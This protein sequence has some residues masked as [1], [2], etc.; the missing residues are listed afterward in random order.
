[1]V[2]FKKT[3]TDTNYGN[4]RQTQTQDSSHLLDAVSGVRFPFVRYPN[5][6]LR[7]LEPLYPESAVSMGLAKINRFDS[8]SWT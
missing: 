3:V 5:I 8:S 4:L 2:A 6:S 7:L 1:M